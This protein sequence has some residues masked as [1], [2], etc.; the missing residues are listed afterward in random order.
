MN[1]TRRGVL[2]GLGALSLLGMG[3]PALARVPSDKRLLVIL[4][5]GGMDG[6]ALVP[7]HN[8][9]DHRTARGEAWVP[10]PGSSEEAAVRLDADFGLHPAMADL[11]PWW[12]A[13]ELAFVHAVALPYRQRS[14]FDAQNVLEGGGVRPYDSDTGWLN[15]AVVAMGGHTV[16]MAM[17]RT[18][19]LT[20]RGAARVTSAD[21]LRNY[22][23]DDGVLARVA[24]LYAADPMLGPALNQSIQTQGM[25]EAHRAGLD[26]SG[27]RKQGELRESAEVIGRVLAAD[28]GP[29]IAVAET[30]GWDT[31]TAQEGT[32]N[33]LFGGLSEGLTGLRT[34]LGDAWE[35]TVI[36]CV[37]EFG[38]TVHANGTGG[39]DHGTASA[40]LLAG[41]GVRGGR[42]I[43][44]WPG[45]GEKHLRDGRD[46]AGTTDIRQVY[47]GVLVNHLGLDM[48]AIEDQVFPGTRSLGPI[49]V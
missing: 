10:D 30:G 46:L 43:S 38:R 6:L 24:D 13:K 34:G 29:R 42:V 35:D 8:D 23:P 9:P 11:L 15:R 1:P 20:L 28:D 7:P 16:P 5:R 17:A 21:P 40:A 25:L 19:P 14:H 3:A 27:G 37:T 39:T 32:L 45:L 18:V 49:T 48:A 26:L 47:K 2:Q 31:H 36:L 12:Q 4:L 41:G 22:T 33:R 44:R